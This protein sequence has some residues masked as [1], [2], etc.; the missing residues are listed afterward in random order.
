MRKINAQDRFVNKK[1]VV[2]LDEGALLRKG[3]CKLASISAP[4][5]GICSGGYK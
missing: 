5:I 3:G 1:A 4:A 2:A